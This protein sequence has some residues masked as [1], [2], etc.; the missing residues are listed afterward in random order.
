MTKTNDLRTEAAYRVAWILNFG[1]WT[2]DAA[3]FYGPSGLRGEARVAHYANMILGKSEDEINKT[4]RAAARQR[5]GKTP[6]VFHWQH[7]PADGGIGW[8]IYPN[9]AVAVTAFADKESRYWG[10]H[11]TENK[12]VLR[13]NPLAPRPGTPE[14]EK[15]AGAL[16][17]QL[18]TAAAPVLD[19][20][21]LVLP[22]VK[23]QSPMTPAARYRL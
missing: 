15:G 5:G 4:L 7:K 10:V 6:A 12:I 1:N 13:V 19:G 18:N 16:W 22:E 2:P 23:A 14:W 20:Q 3:F 8:V 9:G 11:R 17:S 21:V